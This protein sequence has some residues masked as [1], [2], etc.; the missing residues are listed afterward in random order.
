MREEG[1]D[2]AM[3]CHHAV[4]QLASAYRGVVMDAE[5]EG[6]IK[7]LESGVANSVKS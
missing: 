2:R 4:A 5:I 3:R 1:F 6:R 7:A